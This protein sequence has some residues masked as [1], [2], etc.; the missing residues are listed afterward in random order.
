MTLRGRP[1][2]LVSAGLF[3]RGLTLH[4]GERTVLDALDADLPAGE[5]S[6]L[7]GPNGAGKTTLLRTLCRLELP[8]YGAGEVLWGEVSVSKVGPPGLRKRIAYLPATH[9]LPFP[10]P[11]RDLLDAGEPTTASLDR[12][13]GALEIEDFLERP[14]NL[15]SSGEARRAWLAMTLARDTPVILL[16]EPL[17]GLDPRHQLGLLDE[18]ACRA[19][20]GDTVVLALHE[21]TMAARA[22]RAVAISAGQVVAQGPPVEVLTPGLLREIFAVEVATLAGAGV[23]ALVP[24]R[25]V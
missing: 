11:V 13:I 8:R 15:L 25:T 4:K 6:V 7:V 23:T 12:A 17:N 1:P 20:E 24:A 5:L 10:V 3:V 19:R 9:L 18:L 2:G 14:V 22:D 21:L 16:D